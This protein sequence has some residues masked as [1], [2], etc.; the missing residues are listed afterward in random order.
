M[1]FT[2]TLAAFV[3]VAAFTTSTIAAPVKAAPAK[4]AAK[5]SGPLVAGTGIFAK[6]KATKEAWAKASQLCAGGKKAKRDFDDDDYL[7][8]RTAPSGY[9]NVEMGKSDAY[10]AIPLGLWTEGLVT[11]FGVAVVGTGSK[12]TRFL[13]HS[14]ASSTPIGWDDFEK[15]VKGAA[16]TNAQAWIST[17]STTSSLPAGFT[18]EDKALNEAMALA[19]EEKLKTLVGKAPKVVKHTMV[20]ASTMQIAPDGK[21]SVN[22][23][24]V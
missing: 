20:P 14:T 1:H 21:V 23:H 24:A 15:K 3:A 5:A 4:G 8:A 11:C 19:V 13:L 16:L 7:E 22:G 9:T 18:A 6:V 10:G 12:D 2:K 17:P